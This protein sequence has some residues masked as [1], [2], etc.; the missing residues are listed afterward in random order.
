MIVKKNEKSIDFFKEKNDGEPLTE[1]IIRFLRRI[2]PFV[3]EKKSPPK[4]KLRSIVPPQRAGGGYQPIGPIGPPPGWTPSSAKTLKE[5]FDEG[6][7]PPAIRPKKTIDDLN[8]SIL[9][10][11]K[12]C[13]SIDRQITRSKEN[14]NTD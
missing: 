13:K 12:I 7:K 1:T 5:S 4:P 6:S 11:I 3:S 10:L 2:L 14:G 9:N 8:N